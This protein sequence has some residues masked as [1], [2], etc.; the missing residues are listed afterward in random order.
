MTMLATKDGFCLA[1]SGSEGGWRR[2]PASETFFDEKKILPVVFF[3][4]LDSIPGLAT[5]LNGLKS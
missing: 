5:I 2:R 4:F 3:P 1:A